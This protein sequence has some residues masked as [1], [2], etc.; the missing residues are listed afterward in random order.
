MR[1]PKFALTVLLLFS[2]Y[3]AASAICQPGELFDHASAEHTD[4]SRLLEKAK[5][6]NAEAQFRVGLA[7]DMGRGVPCDYAQ[8]ASW[9]RKAAD[10]G[11][12]G[13]QNNLGGLYVRG[14]GVEQNDT[15]AV[16][17]YAR[18]AAEG[19]QAAQNNLGYMYA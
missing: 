15:E 17:W 2:I 9:Y 5:A 18:A 12:P 6:G 14:L 8:A 3:G 13:A 16:R 11:H 7:Y 10:R 19:H 1:S 4:L